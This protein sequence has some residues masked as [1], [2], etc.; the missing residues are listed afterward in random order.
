MSFNKRVPDP[1]T[2]FSHS[3][4]TSAN[5]AELVRFLVQPFLDSP[6]ALSLDCETSQSLSRVW[7]RLAVEA[8][9]K[10]RV[11]GRGGRNIQ[12]IRTVIEAA[13]KAAGQSAYLDIYGGMSGI[14][15]RESDSDSKP[16]PRR[17]PPRRL[18]SPT[19]RSRPR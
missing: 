2:L 7:I 1:V 16:A 10:G 14:S 6:D 18:D 11:F 13:A 12:A 4:N 15:D 9:D 5:Y 3:Q 19:P 8:E 17:S